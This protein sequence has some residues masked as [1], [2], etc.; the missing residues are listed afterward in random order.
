MNSQRSLGSEGGQGQ[1]GAAAEV[2]PAADRA[3]MPFDT[4]ADSYEVWMARRGHR[5]EAIRAVRRSEDYVRALEIRGRGQCAYLIMPL[6]PNPYARVSKRT[7]ERSVQQWRRA[8]AAICESAQ[9]YN[10]QR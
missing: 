1:P 5:M 2:I 7:W 4:N 3:R 9:Y 6:E 10:G 8:F